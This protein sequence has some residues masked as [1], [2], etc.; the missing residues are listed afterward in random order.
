VQ[1]RDLLLEPSPAR[2]AGGSAVH[3][4]GDPGEGADRPLHDQRGDAEPVPQRRDRPVQVG[5]GPVH[6]VDERDPRHA[7]PV[8]LPPDRL[9]LRLDAGHRVEDGDRAVE[10]PQ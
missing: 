6:L 10:H 1:G 4:I 7:V 2:I 5:A 8:G 3:E 9:A